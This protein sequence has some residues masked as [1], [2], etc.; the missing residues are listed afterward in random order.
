MSASLKINMQKK[1][2]DSKKRK[3]IEQKFEHSNLVQTNTEGNSITYFN[4]VSESN[5]KKHYIVALINGPNGIQFECNCGDQWN[6]SPKRNN[7]KHVGGVV[8]NV[9]RTFVAT[10][11]YIKQH[12][13][14]AND[15]A[16]RINLDDMDDVIKEFG[17]LMS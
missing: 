8:G 6:I 2:I 13:I 15:S 10:H 7:C 5:E 14:K 9:V 11:S 4:V 1:T 16:K 12:K 17:K 3:N